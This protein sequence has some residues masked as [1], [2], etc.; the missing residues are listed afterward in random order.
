MVEQVFEVVSELVVFSSSDS[1][2]SQAEQNRQR[3]GRQLEG[4]LH[5]VSAPH[6]PCCMLSLLL[7]VI[8]YRTMFLMVP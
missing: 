2:V 4:L 1:G 5:K 8:N 6:V 3:L 7:Q